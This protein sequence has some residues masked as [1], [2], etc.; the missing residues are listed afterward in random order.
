MNASRSGGDLIL[1]RRTLP[2]GKDTGSNRIEYL[3]PSLARVARRP[4]HESTMCLQSGAA[5]FRPALGAAVQVWG[6][7]LK[8]APHIGW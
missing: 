3:K 1:V 8:A 7:G 5:G 6:R 4:Q 2:V